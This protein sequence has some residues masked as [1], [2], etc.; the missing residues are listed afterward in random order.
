ME[1]SYIK[2]YSKPGAMRAGFEYYRAVLKMQNKTKNM[3]KKN[4]RFLY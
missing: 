2:Q 1:K 3:L 4:W